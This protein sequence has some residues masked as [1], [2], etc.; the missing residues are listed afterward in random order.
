LFPKSHEENKYIARFP[1]SR[2]VGYLMHAMAWTRLH[3]AH[4]VGLVHKFMVDS[5]KKH[6]MVV[7]R[8]FKYL[9]S[10]KDYTLC[11]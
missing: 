10:T 8:L 4:P 11:F 9:Q 3:I 1:Y 2:E 7:K 6:W 5:E